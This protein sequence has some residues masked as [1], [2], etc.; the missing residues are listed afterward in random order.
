M[1]RCSRLGWFR[2]VIGGRPKQEYQYRFSDY[3]YLFSI[4]RG[5]KQDYEYGCSDYNYLP[6]HLSGALR[7]N[8]PSG[9]PGCIYVYSPSWNPACHRRTAAILAPVR[10]RAVGVLV[11][12][13]DRAV[14][15]AAV[16]S[17]DSRYS[18]KPR[19]MRFRS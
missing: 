4:G 17:A 3:E 15:P 16:R 5:P 6:H 14:P 13:R 12:S 2:V 9:N 18:V 11:Y 7:S 19:R 8:R 10:R 1:G